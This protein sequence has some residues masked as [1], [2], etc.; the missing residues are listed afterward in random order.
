[1]TGSR[2]GGDSRLAVAQNGGIEGDE[3]SGDFASESADGWASGSD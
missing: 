2:H 3:R 1:V